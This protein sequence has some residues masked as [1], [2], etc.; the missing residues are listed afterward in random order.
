LPLMYTLGLKGDNEPVS[1]FNDK[2]IGGSLTMTSVK[3]G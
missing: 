3:I 1:I 2:A